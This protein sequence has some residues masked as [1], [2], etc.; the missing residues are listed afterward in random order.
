MMPAISLRKTAGG[1]ASR[2]GS[3][4]TALS[5]PQGGLGETENAVSAIDRFGWQ[6]APATLDDQADADS[7]AN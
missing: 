1:H 3:W 6:G 4:P 2:H 5:G 7:A